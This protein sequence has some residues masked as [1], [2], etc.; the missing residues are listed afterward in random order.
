M[1]RG[2]KGGSLIGARCKS[3]CR[4][5]SSSLICLEANASWSISHWRWRLHFHSNHLVW[6]YSFGNNKL[7]TTLCGWTDSFCFNY[8]TSVLLICKAISE[9]SPVRPFTYICFSITQ[10]VQLCINLAVIAMSRI[11]MRVI[12]EYIFLTSYCSIYH[13]SLTFICPLLSEPFMQ[14]PEGNNG[15]EKE[16]GMQP[17]GLTV[18]WT[19]DTLFHCAA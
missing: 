6:T 16:C 14:Y 5:W 19:G 18:K 10:P 17:L 8:W 15:R 13:F 12:M 3:H 1:L 7:G 9:N 4:S 2:N 11:V